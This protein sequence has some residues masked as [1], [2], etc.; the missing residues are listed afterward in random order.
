MLSIFNEKDR[1]IRKPEI[2]SRIGNLILSSF[3]KISNN[4]YNFIS[5][6]IRDFV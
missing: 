1:D 2:K 4:R 6:K 3:L 5:N